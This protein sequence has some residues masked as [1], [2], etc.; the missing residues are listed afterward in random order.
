VRGRETVTLQGRRS[1]GRYV[2]VVLISLVGIYCSTLTIDGFQRNRVWEL[3]N[4]GKLQV[5][6]IMTFVKI[7][8]FRLNE[9]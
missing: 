3:R 4:G 1:R 8:F 6:V 5:A 9:R 2:R 7:P